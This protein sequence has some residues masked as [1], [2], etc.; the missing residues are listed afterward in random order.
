MVDRLVRGADINLPTTQPHLRGAQQLLGRHLG[1]VGAEARQRYQALGT[2]LAEVR[3]PF[4][5]N[6]VQCSDRLG[7]GDS[8]GKPG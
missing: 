8:G 5:V 6:V 7:L 2:R 3:R 4:V 1:V